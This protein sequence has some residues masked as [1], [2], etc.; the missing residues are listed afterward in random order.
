MNDALPTEARPFEPIGDRRFRI[1]SLDGGGIRG[2]FTASVLATIE[3]MSQKSIPEHFDLIV[4]TSTGGIVA[5][6]LG[7]GFSARRIRDLYVDDGPRIFAATGVRG[8]CLRMFRAQHDSRGLRDALNEVFGDRR[9]GESATRLVIPSFD[10]AS[11]DVHLFKTS[12]HPR[13]KRDYRWKAK[14]VAM[15]TSAAPTYFSI[16]HHEESGLR[17]VDGGVWANNPVAVGMSEAIGV[18]GCSP[19]RIEVLSVGTTA[20]PFHVKPK[21]RH[22]GVLGWGRGLIRL[23]LEA[24]T[25]GMAGLTHAITEHDERLLRIDSVVQRKRFKM[26]DSKH[27]RELRGLGEQ[28]ARRKERFVNERFLDE[29]APTFEPY[30]VLPV[31]A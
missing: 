11:G 8:S 3:E 12:H 22:A 28:V 18:L 27:I 5:L 23:L 15:A 19:S 17:L 20:S 7:L 21:K 2:T 4:G 16:F 30:R 14:D 1:L 31:D 9:L 13:F 29:R 24:Q 25:L 26:D 10:V 6:A